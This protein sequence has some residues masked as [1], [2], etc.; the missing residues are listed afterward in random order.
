[1]VELSTELSW[2]VSK[3][4]DFNPEHW[5]MSSV[6]LLLRLCT[7]SLLVMIPKQELQMA[8]AECVSLVG[9]VLQRELC[10]YVR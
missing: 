4:E 7:T 1:M 10:P 5:W 9:I 2:L 8:F 3:V 6:L